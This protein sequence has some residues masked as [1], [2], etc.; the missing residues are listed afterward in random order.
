MPA[1]IDALHALL[2]DVETVLEVA[3]DRQMNAVPPDDP[4]LETARRLG[5]AT[6]GKLTFGELQSAIKSALQQ[7]AGAETP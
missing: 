5:V 1:N 3:E 6:G 2:K 4:L 7:R